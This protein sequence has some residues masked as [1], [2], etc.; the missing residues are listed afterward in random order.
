M[1]SRHHTIC[2]ANAYLSNTYM[3]IDACIRTPTS[4]LTILLQASLD[5]GAFSQ[6]PAVVAAVRIDQDIG[7]NMSYAI[8]PATTTAATA[9]GPVSE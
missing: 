6:G 4:A 2:S 3:N 5:F 8:I 9:S 1:P 7:I